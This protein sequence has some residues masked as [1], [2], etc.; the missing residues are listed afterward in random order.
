MIG[1]T[2]TAT[3]LQQ[4]MKEGKKR[5]QKGNKTIDPRVEFPSARVVGSDRVVF[6]AWPGMVIPRLRKNR[7]VFSFF[8]AAGGSPGRSIRA[9]DRQG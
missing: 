9:H 4:F 3:K 6:L 2:R 7:P 8:G 1:A 5:E